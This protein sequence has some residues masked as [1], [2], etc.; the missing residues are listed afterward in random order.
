MLRQDVR[1]LNDFVCRGLKNWARPSGL[2]RRLPLRPLACACILWGWI[3][4]P[5]R[6][7]GRP[8]GPIRRMGRG[9]VDR[10]NVAKVRLTHAAAG[11]AAFKAKKEAEGKQGH[12]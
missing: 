1:F 7:K 8:G 9:G 10:R 5:A 11:G 3:E 2:R 6:R 4:A 12:N